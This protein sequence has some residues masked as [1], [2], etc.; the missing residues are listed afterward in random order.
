MK[1]AV[2]IPD[3]I[4]QEA[5]EVAQDLGISRSELYATALAELLKKR[6]HEKITEQINRVLENEES[7][8]D[9]GFIELQARSIPYEEW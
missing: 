6:K 8:L 7:P 9:A 5:E 2:S 3:P 1:T 4:F